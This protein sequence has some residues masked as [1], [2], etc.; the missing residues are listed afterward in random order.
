MVGSSTFSQG[1][2]NSA[3]NWVLSNTGYFL[4]HENDKDSYITTNVSRLSMVNPELYVNARIS[5]LSLTYYGYCLGNGNYT[6]NLHFAEIMFTNDTTYRSLGRR[7]FNVY[8]QV[9]YLFILY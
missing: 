7:I 3:E 4:D 2:R 5:P 8:L 1:T 9:A 6:L